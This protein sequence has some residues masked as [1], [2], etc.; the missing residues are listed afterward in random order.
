MSWIEYIATSTSLEELY[1]RYPFACMPTPIPVRVTAGKQKHAAIIENTICVI[2]VHLDGR[3]PA[4]IEKP[5][6]S[7]NI[8]PHQIP[9]PMAA[10]P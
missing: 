2:I 8:I 5:P 3:Q 1:P 10:N 9:L 7:P 6:E 4:Q